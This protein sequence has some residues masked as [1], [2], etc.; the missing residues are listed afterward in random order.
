MLPSEFIKDINVMFTK[1]NNWLKANLL[2]LTSE[3]PSFMPFLIKNNSNIDINIGCEDKHIPN[4]TYIKFLEIMIDIT[5][6]WK[7]QTEMII[8]KLSSAC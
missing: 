6:T 8:Q 5:L 1:I 3:N 4:T 7:T 2:S